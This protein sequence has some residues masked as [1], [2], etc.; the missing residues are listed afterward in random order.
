MLYLKWPI[1]LRKSPWSKST[2]RTSSSS[3]VKVV[4]GRG[5][6]GNLLFWNL[7]ETR[8]PSVEKELTQSIKSFF[9]IVF[10]IPKSILGMSQILLK[11]SQ[12]N[13]LKLIWVPSGNKNKFS[14]SIEYYIVT[15]HCAVE[16]LHPV[17]TI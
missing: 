1:S 15:K 3:E 12:D 17:L 2:N 6:A 11:A 7:W 16:N 10:F 8:R 5:Q 14:S 4:C 13:D 9:Q